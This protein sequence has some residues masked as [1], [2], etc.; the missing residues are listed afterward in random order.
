[1]HLN[2]ALPNKWILLKPFSFMLD[3]NSPGATWAEGGRPIGADIR[4]VEESIVAKKG[5]GDK[6]PMNGQTTKPGTAPT[7]G[8]KKNLGF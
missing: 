8:G 4:S 5:S 6:Q 2:K 7:V 1:M 3:P